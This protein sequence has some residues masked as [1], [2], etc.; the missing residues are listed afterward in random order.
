MAEIFQSNF[1]LGLKG[2]LYQN[3][4]N[5]V[6]HP[7]IQN[8]IGANDYEV[9]DFDK[10]LSSYDFDY[11]KRKESIFPDFYLNFLGDII[12]ENNTVS[13]KKKVCITL[14]ERLCTNICPNTRRK[15]TTIK[16]SGMELAYFIY[17]DIKEFFNFV[18]DKNISQQK[19]IYAQLNL[20]SH[21]ELLSILRSGKKFLS[22]LENLNVSIPQKQ[23]RDGLI[24]AISKYDETFSQL[25]NHENPIVRELAKIKLE[26]TNN[27]SE[28]TH[29]LIGFVDNH[30]EDRKLTFVTYSKDDKGVPLHHEKFPEAPNLS[31]GDVLNLECS[32]DGERYHVRKYS[33]L[34]TN[35]ISD[36]LESFYGELIIECKHNRDYAFIVSNESKIH[37]PLRLLGN[38][39][40][41]FQ[42]QSIHCMAKNK[43]NDG[44][45][46]MQNWVAIKIIEK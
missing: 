18:Y 41:E 1:V 22:L 35:K 30:N 17:F 10:H 15:I 20:E 11:K 45:S 40:W 26:Q 37:I 9:I 6:A 39:Y 25:L 44:F 36:L 2:N 23:G 32:F 5:E 7:I 27:S 46:D 42:N 16:I 33:V 4:L 21:D 28:V 14:D 34:N 13:F 24:P 19:P 12:K 43:V 31:V 29:S 38:N 8:I 3:F